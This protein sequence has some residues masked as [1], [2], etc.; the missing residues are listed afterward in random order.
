MIVYAHY[1]VKCRACNASGMLM[2]F[3]LAAGHL[4]PKAGGGASHSQYYHCFCDG[5][6]K[7]ALAFFDGQ[8]LRLNEEFAELIGIAETAEEAIA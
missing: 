3:N 4:L 6:Q 1:V 8:D 5:D 7:R 2:N